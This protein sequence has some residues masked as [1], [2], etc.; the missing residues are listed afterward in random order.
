MTNHRLPRS[1]AVVGGAAWV[2]DT[3]L[4]TALDRSFGAP[5]NALFLVGLFGLALAAVTAG[6]ALTA[7]RPIWQRVLAALGA[8]IVA[9]AIATGLDA[10]VRELARALTD[11]ANKGVN[12]ELGLMAVGLVAVAL[13]LRAS[14]RGVAAA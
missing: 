8:F 12:G 1:L 2:L 5:D 9:A 3:T 13:G 4:I 10:G 11:S 7:G 14:H 6:A